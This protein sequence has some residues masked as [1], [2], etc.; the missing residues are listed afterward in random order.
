MPTLST[1]VSSVLISSVLISG[2]LAAPALAQS[3]FVRPAVEVP[4]LKAMQASPDLGVT[5]LSRVLLH[6]RVFKGASPT[7]LVSEKQAIVTINGYY[8]RGDSILRRKDAVLAAKA[9]I[10]YSP[11][12]FAAVSVRYIEPAS[13]GS[14]IEDIV[15]AREITSLTVGTIKLDDLANQI[16]ELSVSAFDSPAALFNKYLT[17]VELAIS[18]GDFWEA[19]V[20]VDA[21]PDSPAGDLGRFTSD[22]L[23]LSSGFD[24]YGDSTRSTRFLVRAVSLLRQAGRLCDSQGDQLIE[25]LV[26]L[27]LQDN[28]FEPAQSLLTGL[29]TEIPASANQSMYCGNLERLALV[30]MKSGQAARAEAPLQEALTIRQAAGVD[31]NLAKTM[32]SLGD[33]YAATGRRGDAQALYLKAKAIYDHAV[34]SRSVTSGA[35]GVFG[36]SGSGSATGNSGTYMD[37]QVY[38]GHIKQLQE[39]LK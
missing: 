28:R 16:I 14:Y 19:G 6:A 13:S 27:Y 3:D 24:S 30:Y 12:Q 21:M 9:I 18:R 37:F 10:N 35:G 8:A 38:R 4:Q 32:E 20:L 34:V 25:R 22:M 39:K 11:T 7:V 29:L 1:L 17:G 2:V 15:S 23:V 33:V 36:R 31:A 26:G 5:N